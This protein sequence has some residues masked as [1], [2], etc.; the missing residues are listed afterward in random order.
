MNKIIVWLCALA[1]IAFSI[2]IGWVFVSNLEQA[3]PNVKASLIG[4]VFTVLGAFL[5]NHLTRKRETDSRHFAER[6]KG[7]MNLVDM[8]FRLFQASRGTEG[9]VKGIEEGI[10][11][12]FG[13]EE[14]RDI[15]MD[16]KKSIMIWG[17]PDLIQAW[18]DY[19]INSNKLQ[20]AP[21][22]ILE[23]D[24]LL[25]AIRKD[26][27]HSDGTLNDGDLVG[28]VLKIEDREKLLEGK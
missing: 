25:R 27:G 24:K 20:G 1:V 2:W 14:M 19:E 12:E 5:I 17:G 18:N 9:D 10:E 8:L 6:R 15:I 7:S 13:P 16:F 22:V 21:G 3:S 26:L 4:G 28:L 11:E 23:M